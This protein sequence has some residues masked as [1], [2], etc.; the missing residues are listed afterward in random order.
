MAVIDRTLTLH[1][2][3]VP[4]RDR[5]NRLKAER[6]E[7]DQWAGAAIQAA[8]TIIVPRILAG[9]W[10][11]TAETID[12]GIAQ[13]SKVAVRDLRSGPRAERCDSAQC[14]FYRMAFEAVCREARDTFLAQQAAIAKGVEAMLLLQ[15]ASD[16]ADEAQAMA[17]RS[18]LVAPAPP[19]LPVPHALAMLMPAPPARRPLRPED[20][21]A[22]PRGGA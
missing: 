4:A 14:L 17:Q 22:L 7:L 6:P 1:H 11:G 19:I 2:R 18:G 16:A 20:F 15:A 8:E 12:R 21:G 5:F 3:D 10:G 9:T 13:A